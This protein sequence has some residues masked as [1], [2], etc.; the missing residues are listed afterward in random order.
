MAD[1]DKKYCLQKM[2]RS[3]IKMTENP[4]FNV[5]DYSINKSERRM[6]FSTGYKQEVKPQQKF[7]LSPLFVDV[8]DRQNVHG[9]CEYHNRYPDH[10]SFA[11]NQDV[12]SL[13]DVKTRVSTPMRFKP[14]LLKTFDA[15][16]GTDQADI[17]PT[18]SYQPHSLLNKPVIHTVEEDQQTDEEDESSVT[19]GTTVRVQDTT[20]TMDQVYSD[21]IQNRKATEPSRLLRMLIDRMHKDNKDDG[22]FREINNEDDHRNSM[23]A[24]VPEF[25]P[26]QPWLTQTQRRSRDLAITMSQ[27]EH[28]ILRKKFDAHQVAYEV[29]L[30]A[31]Q[32]ERE[33]R[34][35]KLEIRRVLEDSKREQD[36]KEA[37]QEDEN[38][39]LW[40]PLLFKNRKDVNTEEKKKTENFRIQSAKLE[41]AF[42]RLN[43]KMKNHNKKTE[44]KKKEKFYRNLGSPD[45]NL[46]RF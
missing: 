22:D 42:K 28:S 14:G 11:K 41:D 6:T 27:I 38:E 34:N 29:L 24:D 46:S 17:V 2:G 40:T 19:S 18:E 10:Q 36:L 7:T 35:L 9:G 20:K 23:N 3:M 5:L 26:G 21:Y 32:F 4:E 15:T 1:G 31:E 16:V 30:H 43:E 33:G 13:K 37:D 25:I 39:N 8:H 12:D 45:S 44:D